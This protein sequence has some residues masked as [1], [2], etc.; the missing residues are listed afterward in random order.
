[1]KI[2]LE[3]GTSVA[4]HSDDQLLEAANGHNMIFFWIYHSIE[5]FLE[6]FR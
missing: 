4:G 2:F 6:Y 1:M 3:H 5:I